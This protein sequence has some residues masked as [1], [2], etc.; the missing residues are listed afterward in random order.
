[1]KTLVGKVAS[2]FVALRGHLRAALPIAQGSGAITTPITADHGQQ[3]KRTEFLIQLGAHLNAGVVFFSVVLAAA[4]PLFGQTAP[5]QRLSEAYRL[6]RE[7]QPAQAIIQLTSLLDSKSLEPAGIG[8]AWDVL[9][10]AFEDQGDFSASRHAFEQSIQAYDGMANELAGHAMAL[11]DFGELYVAT[12]QLDLA[13]RMMEKALRLYKVS[14]DHAGIARASSDLAGALFSQRRVDEGRKY[15]GRAQKESTLT[16][17]LDRDDL[18]TLASLQGWLARS[19]GD[20]RTSA[21][22]YQQSL[23]LLRE[24]HG[25]AHPSSGWGY[26]LLGQIHAET[27]DLS[28]SLTDMTEGLAILGRTLN[29]DD[30]RLLTAEIAYSHVLD[31]VGRHSEAASLRVNAERRLKTFR[32]CNDCVVSATAFR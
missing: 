8:E 28:E 1:M 15:L 27:G 12:G 7:G 24:Y 6:E 30:P 4:F 32:A 9:G 2:N 19:D 14:N 17:Q 3:K 25:D 26:V 20:L 10:L 11:D 23:D 16:N 5:K 22:R 21:S 18:A 13:V 29:H 31:R